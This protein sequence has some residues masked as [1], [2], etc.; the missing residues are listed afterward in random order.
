[1]VLSCRQVT[2]DA[3]RRCIN[4]V[5][6]V[7]SMIKLDLQTVHQ[8]LLRGKLPRY[9]SL[10]S[11]GI[12]ISLDAGRVIGARTGHCGCYA[13]SFILQS[14]Q[15]HLCFIQLATQLADA[16]GNRQPLIAVLQELLLQ[17]FDIPR[18]AGQVF[19]KLL[20]IQFCAVSNITVCSGHQVT[21]FLSQPGIY[22]GVLR[23]G[24][25]GLQIHQLPI[26]PV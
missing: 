16:P 7:G 15:F 6:T 3:L 24:E 11:G 23:R 22:N 17:F 10:P 5:Q 8:L 25:V 19:F 26:L 18:C 21:S 1:M 4:I 9:T 13:L 12:R 14:R 20:I 2:I